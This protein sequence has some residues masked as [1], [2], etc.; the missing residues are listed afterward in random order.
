MVPVVNTQII[1]HIFNL[2]VRHGITETRV[3]VHYLADVLLEAYGEES[4][5]NG[6]GVHLVKEE[7]LTGPASGAKRLTGVAGD[8]FDETFVV[9]SSDALTDIDLQSLVAFHKKRGL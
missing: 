5:L 8:Y 7:E 2:L 4:H 3:N 1:G 9:V 6:M